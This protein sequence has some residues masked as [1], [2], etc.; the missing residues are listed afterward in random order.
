M[1]LLSCFRHQLR[2]LPFLN[3]FRICVLG[4]FSNRLP[5]FLGLKNPKFRGNLC[6]ELHGD[7]FLHSPTLLLLFRGIFVCLSEDCIAS[8][9]FA[10]NARMIVELKV[11]MERRQPS[12]DLLEVFGKG[13]GERIDCRESGAGLGRFRT[14][15]L[16]SIPLSELLYKS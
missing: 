2:L 7:N 1:K 3:F 12:W 6:S 9:I 13:C 11:L 4:G 14:L 5:K 8:K 10:L 16:A 15:V